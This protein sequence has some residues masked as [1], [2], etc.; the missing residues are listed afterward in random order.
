M[1]KAR[2]IFDIISILFAII[3]ILWFFRIDYSDLSFKNNTSEYLG[4]FSMIMG[5]VSLQM[6]KSSIKEQ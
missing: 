5:L 4:I 2:K 3:L 1:K 6:I